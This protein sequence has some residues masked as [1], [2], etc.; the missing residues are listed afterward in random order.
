MN[1]TMATAVL[2][3]IEAVIVEL[4]EWFKRR[5]QSSASGRS[6]SKDGTEYQERS[7]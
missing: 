6:K 7:A 1:K 4:A 3:I 2:V 5:K